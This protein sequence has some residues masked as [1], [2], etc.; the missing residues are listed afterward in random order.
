MILF[1]LPVLYVLSIGP[2]V[3]IFEHF[4]INRHDPVHGFYKP[5]GKIM[6]SDSSRRAKLVPR[7]NP[8]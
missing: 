4:N 2:A 8:D 1:T 7:L 3:W 5:L 6:D